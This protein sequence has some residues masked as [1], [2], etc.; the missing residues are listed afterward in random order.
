MDD[1]ELFARLSERLRDAHERVSRL[2]LPAEQKSSITRRLL[3]ITNVSKRDLM[4][5]S[6]R[7][8]AFLAEL[9]LQR[10]ST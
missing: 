7:L 1:E 6:Q 5:A 3:A 2:D 9:D 10:P 8:D 4:R